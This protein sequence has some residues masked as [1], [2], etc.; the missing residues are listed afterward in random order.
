[1][2]SL[3]GGKTGPGAVGIIEFRADGS[4]LGETP[5]ETVTG[6][7]TQSAMSMATSI[8]SLVRLPKPCGDDFKPDALALGDLLATNELAIGRGD[9]R[10]TLWKAGSGGT[11]TGIQFVKA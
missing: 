1:M 4:F 6:K 3:S 9:V 8:R 5:C 10:L 11:N 2:E 7:W